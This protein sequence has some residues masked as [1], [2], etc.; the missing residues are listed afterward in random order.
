[1]VVSAGGV[2][3]YSTCTLVPEENVDGVEGCL[4]RHPEFRREAPEDMDPEVMDDRG[5]LCVLPQSTGFDGA[6]AARMRRVR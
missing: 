4:S 5:H 1:R 3:V 2:V 6:F